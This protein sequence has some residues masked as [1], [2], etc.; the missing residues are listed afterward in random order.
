MV[1]NNVDQKQ[2]FAF[3]LCICFH[4][5]EVINQAGSQWACCMS[6]SVFYDYSNTLQQHNIN[7]ISSVNLHTSRAPRAYWCLTCR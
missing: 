4:Y 6:E 1:G 3:F 2:M 7:P 5:T